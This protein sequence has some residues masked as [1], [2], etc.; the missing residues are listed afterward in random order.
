MAVHCPYATC[1]RSFNNQKSLEQHLSSPAHEFDCLRCNRRFQ[2]QQAL[3]QHL[4]TSTQ[5]RNSPQPTGIKPAV[6]GPPQLRR[7]RP[8][9][10]LLPQLSS[11]NSSLKPV[12]PR[13]TTPQRVETQEQ[14]DK[15]WSVITAPQ[16]LEVLESISWRCH[17]A[18]SLLQNGY[19]LYQYT[20]DE[21]ASLRKCINCG[22]TI[23]PL[24]VCT[25]NPN[26]S[27]KSIGPK[28]YS[29]CGTASRGCT[30]LPMHY[31]A[32]LDTQ[33]AAQCH[34]FSY[35]PSTTPN[36]PK[37]QVVVLDCE[38]AHVK[39]G[40]AE[41]I[42]VCAVDFITGAVL[43]NHY[44]CPDREITDWNTRI[45]GISRFDV[46][47]AVARGEALLGWKGARDALWRLIDEN[48]ILIGHALNNDLNLLRMLH[49]R[50]VDSGILARQAVG[51]RRQWG[52]DTLCRELLHI[53][54]R[55]NKKNTHNCMEDVL[56]TR[57][58]VLFCIQHEYELQNWAEVKKL[59][60]E[61]KREEKK[62]IQE[63]KK[64]TKGNMKTLGA[65][66]S[67]RSFSSTSE[68]DEIVNW[69]DIAEDLG[70]PHPDTG[71]DPWSD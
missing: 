17:S 40:G 2:S 16:Q 34:S 36:K 49:P 26:V 35:T 63:A 69:S 57:N 21:I 47:N 70:W 59:E 29:C 58:V 33:I 28:I 18:E 68:M 6:A 62:R 53:E 39:D 43:L 45:H 52:L 42:F 61:L 44:V 38:M 46:K 67:H 14:Q 11:S 25:L 19:R 55:N 13:V 56:A 10:A 60:E 22:G 7:F 32:N 9:S 37:F 20:A 24:K 51:E 4:R 71:Y 3:D 64:A 31:Y 50:I 5:H 8:K 54:F 66:L 1:E 15:R 30:S 65:G 12:V 48:T 41:V 23:S 27:Y